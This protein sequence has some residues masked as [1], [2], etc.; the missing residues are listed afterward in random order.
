MSNY[1]YVRHLLPTN[2]EDEAKELTSSQPDG[3]SSAATYDKWLADA[4][5]FLYLHGSAGTRSSSHRLRTYHL[6]NQLGYHVVTFD[7]RGRPYHCKICHL[8][9]KQ[10]PDLIH[11][12]KTMEVN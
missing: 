8:S 3:A 7:Y 5:A 12:L 9:L 6:L 1:F 11:L 4:T 2:L 10:Q